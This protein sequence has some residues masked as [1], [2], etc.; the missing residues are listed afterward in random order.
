MFE[1]MKVPAATVF[2]TVLIWGLADQ[3]ATE[4]LE[5]TVPIRIRSAPGSGLVVSTFGETP[6]TVTVRLAGRQRDINTVRDSQRDPVVIEL[7]RNSV[8]NREL[9]PFELSTLEALQARKSSF[10]G[11]TV[12]SVEPDV[13]RLLIDR[14]EKH[15][16]PVRIK[17]G[18]IQYIAPPRVEPNTVVVNI[19][20]SRFARIK[21][22]Q[23]HILVDAET[24]L[25]DQSEDVALRLPIP[26]ERV[27]HSELGNVS[28]RDIE[29]DTVTLRATLRQRVKDA[30]LQAVPIKFQLSRNLLNGYDIEFRDRNPVETLTVRIS[31]PAE[32]VDRLE[33]GERRTFAIITIGSTNILDQAEYQFFRPELNLPAGVTLAEGETLPNFELRV[34]PRDSGGD[35]LP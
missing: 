7:D 23:P 1:S 26:L 17:P 6:D 25:R 14:T 3:L 13:I 33:S 2:L 12:E 8:R 10:L 24:H 32:E 29:P 15:E 21:D 35:D 19:L 27:V 34:V 11:C 9:N 22:A 4:T 5:I 28:A 31:G 18:Q 30:T 20:R 16:I